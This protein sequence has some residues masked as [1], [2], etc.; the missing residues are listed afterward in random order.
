MANFS[1]KNWSVR[2]NS[3]PRVEF[4][5]ADELVLGVKGELV[6]QEQ[7][8]PDGDD[9]AA[10]GRIS[11]IGQMDVL[12]WQGLIGIESPEAVALQFQPTLGA[13]LVEASVQIKEFLDHAH[14]DP[15]EIF[16]GLIFL[17]QVIE[18][19]EGVILQGAKIIFLKDAPLFLDPGGNFC[20][21]H[22]HIHRGVL[23]EGC[24]SSRFS[25]AGL[26]Y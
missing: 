18:G 2:R 17:G 23:W 24:S 13:D 9:Q 8:A 22:G 19:L 4:Q 26:R 10:I 11:L 21:V 16:Y 7:V 3:A 15:V 1:K 5:H 20:Q 6:H 14:R 25:P 12:G